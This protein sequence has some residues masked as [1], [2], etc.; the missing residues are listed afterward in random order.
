MENT[1][2]SAKQYIEQLDKINPNWHLDKNTIA[3]AFMSYSAK[4]SIIDEDL[5]KSFAG[6]FRQWERKWKLFGEQNFHEKPPHFDEFIKETLTL[7]KK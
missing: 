6:K 5:L 7:L 2:E 4:T 1:F 3:S